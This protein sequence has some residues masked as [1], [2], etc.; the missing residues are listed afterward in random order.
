[1]HVPVVFLYPRFTVQ[2]KI[3]RKHLQTAYKLL[4]QL[5]HLSLRLGKEA[6]VILACIILLLK[7]RFTCSWRHSFP[8]EFNDVLKF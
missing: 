8:Q 1:M 4:S 2:G 3:T 7:N 6:E 5:T